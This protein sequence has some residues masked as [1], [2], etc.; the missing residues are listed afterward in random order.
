MTSSAE[1]RE[2]RRDLDRLVERLHL[3]RWTPEEREEYLEG[4]AEH[5]MFMDAI[6]KDGAPSNE[7]VQAMQAIEY[8]ADETPETQATAAKERGNVSFQKGVA[9]HSNAMRYYKEA[10]DHC[11][12]MKE[13]TESMNK[14]ESQV[15]SN[16]AAILL[17]R[18]QYSKVLVEC[19]QALRLWPEN[20]R[21]CQRA[22]RAC[23]ELGKASEGLDYAEVGLV[24]EPDSKPLLAVKEVA[25]QAVAR[26]RREREAV[27]RARAESEAALDAVRTGCVER[28][29]VL[30]QPAF[31]PLRTART[32]ALP[33]IDEHSCMV[34]PVLFLYPS[35][36]H[37]DLVERFPEVSSFQEQLE[38][39]LPDIGEPPVWDETHGAYRVSNVEVFY[40]TNA[41][42]PIAPATAWHGDEDAE[43][44][45]VYAPQEWVR[46][47]LHA[48]LLL[49]LISAGFVVADT[50][51]FY[52]IAKGTQFYA[53]N[54][55]STSVRTLVVPDL[56]SA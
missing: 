35:S 43:I 7:Y 45:P 31:K 22:A 3:R 18:S 44:E 13:R 27:E 11:K 55:A 23:V 33:F 2:S 4:Q 10:L 15:R 8:D 42:K 21:A 24:L 17:E 32:A 6:P 41:S 34:W 56:P 1:A 29:I 51:A 9:F 12:Q 19:R 20:V 36:G 5:P 53:D 37:N 25:T 50:P 39:V 46:V 49:P 47:P 16:I 48:P 26:Q 30:G 28:G 38:H 14:L 52:I 40:K 54:I